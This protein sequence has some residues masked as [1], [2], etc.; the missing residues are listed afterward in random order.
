MSDSFAQLYTQDSCIVPQPQTRKALS[1][2]SHVGEGYWHSYGWDKVW[3]PVGQQTQ[4]NA[5]QPTKRH[6]LKQ[7]LVNT[8]RNNMLHHH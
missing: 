1:H 8:S 6:N 3:I 5:A 2:W 4:V 7:A